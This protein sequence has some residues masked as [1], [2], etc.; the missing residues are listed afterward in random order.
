M[1]FSP[2][3]DVAAGL[4]VGVVAVDCLRHTRRPAEVPL[5][6]LPLVFAVHQLVE[7]FVWWGLEGDVSTSVGRAAEWVYLAIAFGL[8]PVLVPLAVEA[9]EP[10]TRRHRMALFVALG[11]VVATLL[12]VAVVRGP[13]LT[14]I[15]GYHV[16][17]RVDL[18]QGGLLVLLYVLATCGSLLVSVHSH[19]RA[20]GIANLA[21]VAVLA[22]LN[23]SA[24]I[25]LWCAWAALTSGA[26]ALHLRYAGRD[27]D[28][29]VGVPA[30]AVR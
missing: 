17:Y 29:G 9:L 21:A 24:F 14:R 16:D 1:C 7:A 25:S 6:L 2:E 10:A 28:D 19:V 20:F 22:W 13:I 12:M 26:I 18:W 4:L 11:G 23:Q 8:L 15:E 5:A 27:Q 30:E 3:V